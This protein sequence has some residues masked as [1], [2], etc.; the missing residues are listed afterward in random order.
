MI[1]TQEI[2]VLKIYARTDPTRTKTLREAFARALRRRFNELT[3]VIREAIVDEDVLGLKPETP[4]GYQ[5]APPGVGR[6]NFPRSEDK[7]E[8]FMRWL[9]Q[10]QDRGLLEIRDLPQVGSAMHRRWIDK[11]VYDSYKR[12]VIRAR[13]ELRKAGFDIPAFEQPAGVEATM[14]APIHLDR[15]GVLYTRTFNELKGITE[16]MD[17]H[18]SR[19]LTQGMADGDNPR[20][21]ARKITAAINGVGADRLGLRDTLGR[22]IPGRRRAEIMARTEV[23]RAHHQ[24]TIQEYRNWGAEGVTVQAEWQTAGDERVCDICASMQGEIYTLDQIQNMIPL[25]AQCRCL[26]L[27]YRK[28]MDTPQTW[29]QMPEVRNGRLPRLKRM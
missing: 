3:A 21:M 13:Y 29:N 6:F 28:G 10:Q 9:R 17:Q 2:G 11:Y 8:A 22:W 5:M 7:V 18:I 25:H 15:L 19:V 24:A 16:A 20:L 12:G 26:A 23:I 27:P 1:D 14:S 4:Q